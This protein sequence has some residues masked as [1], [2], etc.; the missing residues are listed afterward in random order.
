MCYI[1][2]SV[3]LLC[4]MVN[5]HFHHHLGDVS[6]PSTKQSNPFFGWKVWEQNPSRIRR[7]RVPPLLPELRRFGTEKPGKFW[8]KYMTAQVVFGGQIFYRKK[9]KNY[10]NL[11]LTPHNTDDN[12][13]LLAVMTIFT[14]AI[15]APFE[16]RGFC[17]WILVTG[18]VR[19]SIP[20]SWIQNQKPVIL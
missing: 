1:C 11:I 13:S 18:P 3:F 10:D 15:H 9:Q 12:Q 14:G 19:Y 5:H 6:L 20:R 8:H 17:R 7:S 4:T 2:W 16:L